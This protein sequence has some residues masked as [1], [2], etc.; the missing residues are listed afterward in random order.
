MTSEE[1]NKLIMQTYFRSLRQSGYKECADRMETTYDAQ[2]AVKEA[3]RII[4]GNETE[5]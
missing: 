3:K 4:N 1:L 5:T 2:Q